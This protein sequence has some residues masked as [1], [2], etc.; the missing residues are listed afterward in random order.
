MQKL[1]IFV[2]FNGLIIKRKVL[3]YYGLCC[4]GSDAQCDLMSND[5]K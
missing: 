2:R 5:L 3:H 1:F 4:T